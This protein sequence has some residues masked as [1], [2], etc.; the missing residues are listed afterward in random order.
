M[1]PRIP[2]SEPDLSGN[3]KAYV[4]ECLETSWISSKGRFIDLFEDIFRNYIGVRHAITTSNGTASLHLALYALGVKPG[5]EVIV[6]A[7]TYVAPASAALHLGAVPV[8]VDIDPNTWNLTADTVRA[9]LTD[10]TRGVIAVHLFGNPVDMAPLQTLCRERGLWLIEDAAEALGGEYRGR[11]VGALG[12]VACFSFFGNKTVSTGEGGMIT[13]DHEEL[14]RVIRRLKNQG[15][16]PGRRYWHEMAGFNFR[17]TNLQAAVGLAQMEQVERLVSRKQAIAEL[18]RRHLRGAS[19]T[20]SDVLPDTVHSYWMTSVLLNS[21]AA[22]IT[23]DELMERLGREGIE[24]RPFFY[25]LHQLP[26]FQGRMPGQFPVTEDVSV[27]GVTLPGSTRLRDAEVALVSR[28]LRACLSGDRVGA[29]H[30]TRP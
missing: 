10:R 21:E 17:M 4:L 26:I 2:I 30:A 9:A 19:V 12:D 14:A 16:T 27:R 13:T 5:D 6:P 28:T 7:L 8:A 23:R 29:P 11:K 20:F 18:Y 24:T 1:S 3:E 15:E 25:P 22:G